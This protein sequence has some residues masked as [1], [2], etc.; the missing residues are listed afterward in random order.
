MLVTQVVVTVISLELKPIVHFPGRIW[1]LDYE[2]NIP[3]ALAGTQLALVSGT[4]FVSAWLSRT[5]PVYKRLYLV[6]ISIVFLYLAWD[7]YF[8]RVRPHIDNWEIYYAALG[9]I[10][11][12]ATLI[13]AARSPRSS[14]I[15]H[16]SFLAG[17]ALS[18][19]GALVLE[20]LKS[21][22]FC[23]Q[24]GLWSSGGCKIY[25]IEETLEYLG[26]WLTLI[27]VLGHLTDAVP[28]PSRQVRRLLYLLPLA[29]IVV[30]PIP[31]AL[32]LFQ[33]LFFWLTLITLV[34]MY[35]DTAPRPSRILRRVFY[36]LSALWLFVA[37]LPGQIRFME[38]QFLA[39]PATLTYES[40]IQVRIYHLDQ[41][42]NE[43][44]LQF[45]SEPDDIGEY[46][47]LG[48]SMHLVDQVSGQSIASTDENASYL[49]SSPYRVILGSNYI[50]KQHIS[51][52]IPPEAPANRALWV[53]LTTWREH[54][55]TFVSQEITSSDYR[56]L[57]STQVVL[58]EL[59]L[60][61]EPVAP[62]SS[63]IAKFENGFQL[64]AAEIPASARADEILKIVFSWGSDVE[65]DEDY[66]QFL[67]FMN[68]ETGN[69]WAHDQPPLGPQ[70]PTRLWY[71]GLSSNETWTLSPPPEAAPGR[72]QVF[73]GLYAS[74][75][76]ERLPASAA[77]E[78]SFADARIPL[79][80][81]T[82]NSP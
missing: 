18:A 57:N 24:L 71:S 28:R 69:W 2:S 82:I 48:Y 53:V 56:M 61:A 3:A 67:H 68:L 49:D 74:I 20:Q 22:E 11:V 8:N 79:G 7:E 17:L 26:I 14:R 55:N 46:K 54:S 35:A 62:T 77:D 36:G 4:A 75:N 6:G 9:A 60:P 76:M 23:H 19:A 40:G 66:I 44:S 73:T 34:D 10:V 59:T 50:F 25:V 63:P 38:Y 29:W 45:F 64:L 70:L 65:G 1:S 5:Q 37:V 72:Y 81:L 42:E 47:G 13:V 41:R 32:R 30:I 52:N 43:I 80:T 27:A 16:I 33:Q 31:T 78:T 58:D 15:W 12:A 21:P 39:E 51:V